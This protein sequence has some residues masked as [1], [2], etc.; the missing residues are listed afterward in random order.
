MIP[1]SVSTKII[2]DLI[3]LDYMDSVSVIDKEAVFL[4]T[5]TIAFKDSVI[6]VKDDIIDNLERTDS[7]SEEKAALYR[8]Q[9]NL[10]EKQLKR[11]KRK[12]FIVGGIGVLV[13]VLL[14]I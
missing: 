9:L 3:R 4:L 12:I 14:N 13:I 6:V 2:K 11:Q 1:K 7:L 5:R 10:T 8:E